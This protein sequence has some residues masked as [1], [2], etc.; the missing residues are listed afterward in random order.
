MSSACKEQRTCTRRCRRRRMERAASE[1]FTASRVKE[2]WSLA[3]TAE[4]LNP[5][6]S[7]ELWG[8]RRPFVGERSRNWREPWNRR[9]LSNCGGVNRYLTVDSHPETC[10]SCKNTPPPASTHCLFNRETVMCCLQP[11][12]TDGSVKP[13]YSDDTRREHLHKFDLCSLFFMDKMTKH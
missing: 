11:P 3:P 12:R 1:A 7:L 5:P 6:G 8:E 13:V 10:G 4:D 2:R 9:L